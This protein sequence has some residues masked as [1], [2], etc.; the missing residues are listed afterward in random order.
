MSRSSWK[1]YFINSVLFKLKF[2]KKILIWSKNTTITGNLKDQIVFVYNGKEFKKLFI[3]GAKIGF[4]FGHFIF[5]RTHTQKY[6][7]KEKKNK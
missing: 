7:L 2:K 4:K 3:N 1:G 6:K 5:T